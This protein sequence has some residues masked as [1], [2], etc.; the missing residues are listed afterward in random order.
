M[1]GTRTCATPLVL[2][3]SLLLAACGLGAS[4][5]SSI[6]EL[7]PA[8]AKALSAPLMTDPDLARLNEANAALSGSRDHS[9]PLLV[10][11]PQAIRDAQDRAIAL[12]GGRSALASLPEPESLPD[13]G[14]ESPL[15]LL[16]DVARR[17]NAADACLADVRYSAVWA[18]KLPD[19]LPVYPR[20]AVTEAFGRDGPD[21]TV[22][23]VRFVSPVPP[24]DMLQFYATI[25]GQE[26]YTLTYRASK[27]L[28][29]LEGHKPD[30]A[31]MV[32]VRPSLLGGQE[33]DLIVVSGSAVSPR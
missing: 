13:E 15:V 19:R 30:T 22:R 16:E 3:G 31:F 20:G 25:A 10:T 18:S 33:V 7:D 23:A 26:K 21:C 12:A 29:Q 17:V 4:D 32:E 6:A 9:L 5:E 2:V 8:V 14:E 11:T 28:W 1:I 27:Q 24:G